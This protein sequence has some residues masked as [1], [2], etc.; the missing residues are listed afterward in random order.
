[1]G[2]CLCILHP[3]GDP[4]FRFHAGAQTEGLQ[5]TICMPVYITKYWIVT[6]CVLIPWIFF[7]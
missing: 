4:T 7:F 2:V 6:C 3:D 1:M 5:S